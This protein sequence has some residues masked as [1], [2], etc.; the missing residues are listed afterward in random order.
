MDLSY[1]PDQAPDPRNWLKIPEGKRLLLVRDA[2]RDDG[3]EPDAL[4][5]HANIQMVIENQIAARIGCVVRAMARLQAEGL[6]RH[7]ALHAL[8]TVLSEHLHLV[9]QAEQDGTAAPTSDQYHA[10]MERLTTARWRELLG[11]G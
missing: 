9:S 2:H 1:D 10:E 7:D 11:E 3:L 5:M 6:G 8:A 4:L